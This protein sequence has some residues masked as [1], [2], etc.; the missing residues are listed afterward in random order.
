MFHNCLAFLNLRKIFQVKNFGLHGD[1]NPRLS[2][3]RA[4]V[5]P[6]KLQSTP[7]FLNHAWFREFENEPND[8]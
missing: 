8:K 1:S 7:S 6:V 3:C 5:L 4:D 2:A